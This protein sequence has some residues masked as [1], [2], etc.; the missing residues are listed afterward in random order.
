MSFYRSRID[1]RPD[2]RSR[3]AEYRTLKAEQLERIKQRDNFLNLNIVAIGVISSVAIQGSRRDVIWLLIPWVTF[4]LGWV[5]LSNDD[6]ITAIA[7][8]L[9]NAQSS[10]SSLWE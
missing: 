2:V 7:Q 9:D 4:I 3:D 5:Y 1:R 8:H 10:S 6:K